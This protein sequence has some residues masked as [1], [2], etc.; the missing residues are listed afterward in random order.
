MDITMLIDG[1]EAESEGKAQ[2]ERLNPVTGKVAT[3]APAA[4]RADV[5]RAVEASAA[6]FP[7]WAATG[8]NARRAILLKAADALDARTP[9]FIET[10]MAETG[11]TGPWIG[12]NVFF[13]AQMLREAAAMTTQVAGEII[14]SDKPGTLA[15]ALREPVGVLVGMAPW[16]APVILG[17]RAVAMPL[18]CG[19][20]VVFKASEMCPA[21]HRLIVETLN[22]AGLAK[23]VLN[24]IT[25]SA[26]DAPEVVSALIAH[27]KV[28]RINFTGSTRVG[29]IIAEQAGRH[30]KPVLLELG[31]K[32][33]LVVLDDAD[34]D[35]AVN[36][37]AFG[38]FMNQGQ[39]CMSTEKIIVDAS[40]ADGFVERLAAKA[41]ALPYGEPSGQVVLGSVINRATIDRLAELI[42][43]AVGKGA[44]LVTGGTGDTTIMPATVLDRVTPDM[45][46]YA[47]ESFGPIV[48]VVRVDGPDQ[49][50]AAANDTD[51]GLSAAVFGRDVQRALG[52]A[53]R[54]E[55]GIVH[56][57]GPTVQDEAQMPFGGVKG[58]GYGRFGGKAG[59]DAF[60]ELRWVT[61]EDAGQH[62]PF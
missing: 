57:N 26:E 31:G 17:V 14:P 42:D 36:A 58:S 54:I 34:L 8:P 18:A 35:G 50:V 37:A 29:R 46:I 38:A 56:V 24:I 20:T 11:A 41:A 1:A 10:A 4:G 47:E 6:A 9:E 55:S 33:P 21:T 44:M 39:I 52:V 16:N 7:A 22:G 40:V 15:M 27:P 32:A 59:I 43:D 28:R 51:Y 13:A 3:R 25:H 19:N 61:I 48:A 45:R 49:A 30:L 60:T 62:Y 2:F 23:G 5:D 53:R 12:F